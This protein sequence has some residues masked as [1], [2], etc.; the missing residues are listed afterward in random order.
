MKKGLNRF[1]G[2]KFNGGM[3]DVF[4]FQRNVQKVQCVQK[5]GNS[6]TKHQTTNYKQ[7][8][9]PIPQNK[10]FLPFAKYW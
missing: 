4:R 9:F 1:A 6:N 3:V 10:P 7:Q 2:L 5:V 8:T